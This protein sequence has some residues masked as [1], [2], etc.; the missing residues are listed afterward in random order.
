MDS[1]SAIPPPPAGR[2]SGV[3]SVV[4]H[5]NATSA[6]IR[7]ISERRTSLDDQYARAP[8]T[9]GEGDYEA[10]CVHRSHFR[11]P[12]ACLR[13]LM[14][15]FPRSHRLDRYVHKPIRKRVSRAMEVGRIMIAILRA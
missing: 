14:G 1:P 4:E 15:E 13:R 12:R 10:E 7:S 2:S 6:L 8:S 3:A 5:N 9:V 11:V